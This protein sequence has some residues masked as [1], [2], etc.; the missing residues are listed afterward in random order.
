MQLVGEVA[1]QVTVLELGR[2]L[3]SGTPS[4]IKD[5]MN[6]DAEMTCATTLAMADPTNPHPTTWTSIGHSTAEMPLPASTNRSGR[7]VS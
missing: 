4:E 3:S 7:T 2:V 5:R 6:M 1:D